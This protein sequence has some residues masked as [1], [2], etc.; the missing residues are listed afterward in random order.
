MKK[1]KEEPQ[2]LFLKTFKTSFV[3]SVIVFM[4]YKYQQYMSLNYHN[5]S[6]NSFMSLLVMMNVI[7]FSVKY[8]NPEFANNI[9]YGIGW[10]IGFAL[11]NRIVDL[12]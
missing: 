6:V 3:L 9:M 8:T 5:H 4:L 10:G 12:R 1:E 11:L 2:E 7:L